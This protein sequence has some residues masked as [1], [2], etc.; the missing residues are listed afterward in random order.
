MSGDPFVAFK[1]RAALARERFATIHAARMAQIPTSPIVEVPIPVPE[2]VKAA[3]PQPEVE[4]DDEPQPVPQVTISS[5]VVRH[6]RSHSNYRGEVDKV[7]ITVGQASGVEPIPHKA[8]QRPSTSSSA[9]AE[10]GKAKAEPTAAEKQLAEDLE[11]DKNLDEILGWMYAM[12]D[13]YP[14]WGCKEIIELLAHSKDEFDL[15]KFHRD[16]MAT[17]SSKVTKDIF[18]RLK[19]H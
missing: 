1:S 8:P 11:F 13:D 17:H 4:S 18:A 14:K 3:T 12:R 6:K 7:S 15:I 19:K 16:Q 9:K 2:V 10:F 5:P